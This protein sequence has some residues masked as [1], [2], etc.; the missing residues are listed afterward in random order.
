MDA[1]NRLFAGLGI[2]DCPGKACKGFQKGYNRG[3]QYLPK[4]LR[5]KKEE[6]LAFNKYRGNCPSTS[7]KASC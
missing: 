4:N 7:D 5:V 1:K 2:E 6:T 3:G